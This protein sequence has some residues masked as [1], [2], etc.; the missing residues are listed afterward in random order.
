MTFTTIN[1]M[2]GGAVVLILLPNLIF[3]RDLPMVARE[4]PFLLTLLENIG[5]FGCMLL[6]VLPLGVWK[7]GFHSLEEFLLWLAGSLLLLLAYWLVWPH[8]RNSG[9]PPLALALALLPC[10]LFL[11]TGLLLRHWLLVLF[12]LLFAAA[13]VII[14]V[15][16]SK[17]GF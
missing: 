5:R 15:Q 16:N 2:T 9:D 10:G 11:L 8:Y 4:E 12:A 14:T 17:N 7:F 13:H 3:G 1:A 6:M